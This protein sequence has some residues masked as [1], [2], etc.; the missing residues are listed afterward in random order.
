MKKIL[1]FIISIFTVGV[2]L[3][4]TVNDFSF[5]PQI[6][7]NNMSVVFPVGSLSNF[8]GGQLKAFVDGQPVS[9]NDWTNIGEDGSAGVAVVGTDNLCGCDLADGGETIEFAILLDGEFIV[10]IDYD[11]PLTYSANL[12]ELVNGSLTFLNQDGSCYSDV[13]NDGI[14]DE[15]EIP[16]CQGLWADNFDALATDDDSSCYK[17]G[18][19][20][21]FE[22]DFDPYAT[23]NQGCPDILNFAPPVTDNN[24]T[25]IFSGGTLNDYEGGYLIAY[26][27]GAPVSTPSAIFANG[28]GGV[29]VM[30]TDN[31]CG[32]DLADAG[33]TIEF[34]ILLNGDIVLVDVDP[35][36]TYQ[37]SGFELVNGYLTFSLLGAGCMADWADNYST[38]AYFDD[39][40]CYK[41]GCTDPEANNYD[42]VSTQDD[43]SCVYFVPITFQL[44]SGWNMVGYTGTADNN[45]IVAQMDAA[46]GNGAGTANTFQVIKNVSGQFWSAAFAQ[47]NTF[48]QG[49]GYM[50]YV[51]GATTTV[52]FQQTSGYISGIEYALSGG[53]NM[54]A[55]TGDV[56]AD[57]NIVSA[58]D[59]ALVNGAGTANTF[60]VIKN[61]SG[62]FW[63]A[64]FAQIS[65]FNP[66]QAYMMYVNGSPTTVNFQQ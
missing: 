57:N 20:N 37:A 65:T 4:Q 10:M 11:P 12:F 53:W 3:A 42:E 34:M 23:I 45:G 44:S 61:V 5:E 36:L 18:C 39:G 52:N 43:G 6:T 49:Q 29:A 14:C 15:N 19:T 56:D 9:G 59:A 64:A 58:M 41:N 54:V 60:Q 17:M 13:D 31:L 30:G 40:S 22:I 35:P 16:G 51:N 55:F 32:C 66:G 50:M 27:D 62:Q 33:E 28:S 8:I 2:T 1:L 7:D 21:P 24:M 25:V 26:I 47:I 38:D 63:S 48:N 46:L